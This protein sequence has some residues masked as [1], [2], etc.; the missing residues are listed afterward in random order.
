MRKFERTLA[1]R[2]LRS[3]GW[4]TLLTV[5]AVAVAV[6]LVIF[7]SSLIYAL[8]TR[9]AEQLTDYLPHVTIKPRELEPIPLRKVW[10]QN[11]D[12]LVA[13]T[14]EEQTAQR[15]FIEEWPQVVKT[16]E[17]LPHVRHISP[18]VTGQ[19]FLRRG[20][21]SQG[22]SVFGADPEKQQKIAS[23]DKYLVRGK[24]LG[25]NSEEAVI[26]WALAEEFRIQVGDRVRITSSE[27]ANQSFRIAGI[28]D[29]GQDQ[30]DEVRVFVNLPAAQSL[31][32]TGNYV[33]SITL[34]LDNLY[35]ANDVADRIE[36][37]TPYKA[38][39]WMREFASFITILSMQRWV[40]G[41]ISVFSLIASSL[42][43]T[44]VLIV[45]VLQKSR[46]IGIL[47]A[48]GA[49]SGQ[50]LTVFTLEGLYIALIGAA[51]GA[52]LGAGLLA[53]LMPLKQQPRPS[54]L[55]PEP[56]FPVAFNPWIFAAAIVDAVVTTMLAAILP[57]RRAARLDPVQVIR[58]GG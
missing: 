5:G 27:G 36:A 1:L 20:A 22:I 44:S 52:V 47:K 9:L 58:M 46:Q 13:S 6:T 3:G 34:K 21:K 41:M 14:V 29:T 48:M 38:E 45:S 40:A 39:S 18:A 15:K 30:T 53:I 26:G 57:A 7:I 11:P 31:F 42:G 2:H 33:T 4:Q 28:Y 17:A 24:Y 54:G 43:I 8:Q 50:I 51:V 16:V 35:L 32:G 23:L 49:K 55:P 25:I 56:L 19:A 37:F 10:P 12:D